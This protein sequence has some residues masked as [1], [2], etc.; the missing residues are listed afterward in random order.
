MFCPQIKAEASA[1]P[2][3]TPLHHFHFKFVPSHDHLSDPPTPLYRFGSYPNNPN[4]SLPWPL[5]ASPPSPS[6]HH[7]MS[8]SDDY[9]D[10]PVHSY[11]SHLPQPATDRAVRRRSSKACDQCRKSK[12]KCERSTSNEPCKSCILLG[13]PCTFLGP[14]RKRGPPKGY[15]D[16][17][18]ARLHQTEALVGIMLASKDH[19]AQSLL[20]DIA[21]DT[22]AKEIII[23]VDSSPYGVKGRKIISDQPTLAT[24]K[25]NDGTDSPEEKEGGIVDLTSTHPSTEWQD[26]VIDMLG[27]GRT[28]EPMYMRLAPTKNGKPS[29]RIPAYSSDENARSGVGRERQR[30]RLDD[31]YDDAPNSPSNSCSSSAKS[32]M[33]KTQEDED[34]GT[35][36]E[37]QKQLVEAV[38]ELSLNEDEEVRYH[39]QA[40]GLYILGVQERVDKRNE[41]GIWRFPGARVWPPLP[42]VT[43][44]CD[45][46]D[47]DAHLARQKSHT[48][49]V[50]LSTSQPKPDT[51]G[52]RLLPPREEQ[53]RLLELY[54]TYV[55][56]S[57][58]VIHK[59]A[60]WELWRNGNN[61]N[62]HMK[63]KRRIA[64]LLLLSMFALAARYDIPE[65]PSVSSSPSIPN[66]SS[67]PSSTSFPT[68][69]VWMWAAG[70]EYFNSAK[71]LLD[72]SYALSRPSTCQALL[73]MGFREIG[74]GAMALAWTYI[75]MAI[76]MAQDLGMH[77]KAE[78]WR[79]PDLCAT[80]S[81][82][83]PAT[84][85]EGRIF[86][87]WELG[88]RRRIWFGCVIMDK[89]VSAYIGRPLMISEKDFDTEVPE[90]D[91]SEE[92]EDW[93]SINADG[94]WTSAVPGRVISCFNYC[95]KLSEILS[96][97][98]QAIY[99]VRPFPG[100]PG[101]FTPPVRP[102]DS[103]AEMW[104]QATALDGVLDRWYFD[105]PEHLR[106]DP[107]ANIDR[108]PTSAL[109]PLHILTLHMQYWCA[110]LLLHRP[111]IRPALNHRPRSS[112]DESEGEDLIKS[113]KSYELCA[114]AASHITSI[115]TVC[116]KHY[117][118][119]RCS[120][121]LCYYV[122][123]ASIMH[124]ATLNSKLD[125]PQA[126][127]NLRRCMEALAAMR[128][129]WPSAGR[130]LELLIGA[131]TNLDIDAGAGSS[132]VTLGSTTLRGG[133]V[134][135]GMKNHKRKTH[136]GEDARDLPAPTNGAME[137]AEEYAAPVRS[138]TP[139]MSQSGARHRA[140]R[141]VAP[142][143]QY[144]PIN[145]QERYNGSADTYTI[146]PPSLLT[147]PYQW[148]DTSLSPANGPQSSLVS[149][150]GVGGL[151]RRI[152]PEDDPEPA[153]PL[154][155]SV[156]PQ[157][158]STGL[159]DEPSY[160]HPVAPSSHQ[161]PT[162]TQHGL[163]PHPQYHQQYP[164]PSKMSTSHVHSHHSHPE[165]WSDYST[166]SQLGTADVG[167][168][169]LGMGVSQS[170]QGA[171]HSHLQSQMISPSQ[172]DLASMYIPPPSYE[173]YEADY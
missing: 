52:D 60:F 128:N 124:V 131:K 108:S 41:G 94:E 134:T 78:G 42:S 165:Y 141:N 145:S 15:I 25:Q 63:R 91:Q 81:S 19:R 171:Q 162:H 57:F 170:L 132:A 49:P 26:K 10:L 116:Q 13:T 90:V 80:K 3:L 24:K 103:Q 4:H 160:P 50:E 28:S 150:D 83:V 129:I 5:P 159:V 98:I 109:P 100:T 9:D 123:T 56:P 64:P 14:S 144:R 89:Y 161:G 139:L 47:F 17:I 146:Q 97:V 104:R 112:P 20:R 48:P 11:L 92:M 167:F 152:H 37:E 110:V 148:T 68:D 99:A 125:D 79:R 82:K 1:S 85:E 73:L 53:E 149:E 163:H 140:S 151:V 35:E 173:S 12:C 77:R 27:A 31:V 6:D 40:S 45:G 55:Q 70:E 143:T 65:P 114:R 154:S 164:H 119:N 158:Y 135:S 136:P 8:Y 126:R 69:G 113:R 130:A 142:A 106:Y 147:N 166:F 101:S 76:R 43:E 54:F 18:E 105:L 71:S 51:G 30:R 127:I 22:L 96:A 84:E 95:A 36:K 88:E 62:P 59:K 107:A 133:N 102:V 46:E 67:S 39:G 117:P 121:F 61:T 93:K 72:T 137:S 86:G 153:G 38:G 33:S 115:V 34:A 29:L 75:G 122:F 23:R 138:E 169:N 66:A 156:L 120:V 21:Q 2:D 7:T 32:P 118:L 111:F 157:L 168:N 58:P 44:S 87:D 74:I 172:A 155:T 16:A